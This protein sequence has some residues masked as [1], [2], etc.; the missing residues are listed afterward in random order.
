[1]LTET[2][3]DQNHLINI[4]DLAQLGDALLDLG[5]RLQAELVHLLGIQRRVVPSQIQH[6]RPRRRPGTYTNPAR[7]GDRALGNSSTSRST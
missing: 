1:M 3:P 5:Q 7:S 4:F 2:T 6:P